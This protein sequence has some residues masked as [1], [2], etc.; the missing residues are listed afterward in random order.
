[1][2]EEE[3]EAEDEWT[4]LSEDQR[5]EKETELKDAIDNASQSNQMAARSVHMVVMVTETASK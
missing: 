5:K 2:L 1:M 4:H 3:A